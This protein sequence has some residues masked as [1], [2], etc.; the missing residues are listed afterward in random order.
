M[1]EQIVGADCPIQFDLSVFRRWKVPVAIVQQGYPSL[2]QGKS[3]PKSRE[4]DG[5]GEGD[6][7]GV[8]TDQ[9][10]AQDVV[11]RMD[12]E[13]KANPA[14]WILEIFPMSYSFQDA[15]DKWTTRWR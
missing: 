14:W 13:L 15:Q 6:G 7:Y 11:Q 8:D 3:A 12:D 10:D 5:D 4:R 1:I 9:Q 2:S